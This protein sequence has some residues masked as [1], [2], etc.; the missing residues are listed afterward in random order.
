[1]PSDRPPPRTVAPGAPT[2]G[3]AST[4]GAPKAATRCAT[5][6][7]IGPD[8]ENGDVAPCQSSRIGVAVSRH[9]GQTVPAPSAWSRNARAGS[10]RTPASR[11]GRAP[12]CRRRN[13][14]RVGQD[15][16][17]ARRAPRARCPPCPPTPSGIH[18]SRDAVASS[19]AGSGSRRTRRRRSPR[20]PASPRR[21]RR[22]TRPPGSSSAASA[23]ISAG[24]G[25]R[26]SLAEV[27]VEQDLHGPRRRRSAYSSSPV[28]QLPLIGG[29]SGDLWC[30]ML[31]G[32]RLSVD[33]A[34]SRSPCTRRGGCPA[35]RFRR[36]VTTSPFPCRC[37]IAGNSE[38]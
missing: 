28:S 30:A 5:S 27:E 36:T 16:C 29:S 2:G 18:R 32:V 9:H 20:A 24:T 26:T 4:D 22:R 10:G 25:S 17:R 11:R 12:R 15:E 31:L 1:M 14:C 37:W 13:A 21:R 33:E 35:L 7:P 3:A 23:S 38:T 6:R 8:A 34:S 19:G